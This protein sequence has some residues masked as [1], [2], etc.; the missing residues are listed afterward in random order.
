MEYHVY[1]LFSVAYN[2]IYIGYTN[3]VAGRLASHNVLAKNGWTIK[4]RTWVLIHEE[5]FQTK[6]EA[7]V[8]ERQLKSAQGRRWI[9]YHLL[10]Q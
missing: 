4:Y 10:G 7:M 1:V 2:Q 5:S 8:R 9:R 3:D 6:K